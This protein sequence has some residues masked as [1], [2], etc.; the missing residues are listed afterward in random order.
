MMFRLYCSPMIVIATGIIQSFNDLLDKGGPMIIPLLVL[1]VIGLTLSFERLWF[2]LRTNNVSVTTRVGRMAELLRRRD[3]HAAKALADRHHT[4]YDRIVHAL[5]AEETNEAAAV[6]AIE[7]QRPRMDRFMASL[8]TIITAAPMLGILGTVL[9]LI[10]AFETLAKQGEINPRDLSP[11]IGE[12]L[13][14]TAVG[15]V[16]TVVILFPYNACRAQME[17][18]LGRIETL[19]AAV[20][21]PEED[22]TQHDSN[23]KSEIRNPK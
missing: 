23:P 10:G 6:A 9:G 20:V 1:S 18:A 17:R 16:I 12:A 4:V 2:W 7:Q 5:L 22:S 15:L 21:D 19:T 11:D 3:V 8:S 14:S 13:I